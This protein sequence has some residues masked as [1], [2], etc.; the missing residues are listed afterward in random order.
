MCYNN[1]LLKNVK[2]SDDQLVQKEKIITK[3]QV[4]RH[5]HHCNLIWND[6]AKLN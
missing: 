5:T 6:S 3:I 2:L 4:D 1:L